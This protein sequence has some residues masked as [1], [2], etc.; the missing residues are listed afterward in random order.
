M[1]IE[2][3]LAG[4]YIIANENNAKDIILLLYRKGYSFICGYELT[5]ALDQYKLYFNYKTEL[6]IIF[7]NSLH[8]TFNSYKED[9]YTYFD[10]NILLR[11]NK[12]KRILK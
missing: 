9:G 7:F 6:Y 5:F 2:M 11:E 10:V 8:F 4:K 3:N 1:I 12:L